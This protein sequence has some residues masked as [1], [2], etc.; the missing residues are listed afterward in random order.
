MS[1]WALIGVVVL[2]LALSAFFVAAEFALISARRTEVEP[3]AVTSARARLT[4]K[5]ME[6]VSVMMACARTRLLCAR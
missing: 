1:S 2:L 3:R 4:L 6:D 5:A